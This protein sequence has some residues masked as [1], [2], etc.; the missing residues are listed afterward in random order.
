M[1]NIRIRS[2]RVPER[3]GVKYLQ[4][5]HKKTFIRLSPWVIST[6]RTKLYSGA[7]LTRFSSVPLT[8]SPNKTQIWS[9]RITYCTLPNEHDRHKIDRCQSLVDIKGVPSKLDSYPGLATL[10][11]SRPTDTLRNIQLTPQVFCPSW[12]PCISLEVS[13]R[14]LQHICLLAAGQLSLAGSKFFVFFYHCIG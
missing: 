3:V 5:T 11:G 4:Q 14:T 10:L 7:A 2:P 9:N 13:E 1:L 12:I 8:S 6:S